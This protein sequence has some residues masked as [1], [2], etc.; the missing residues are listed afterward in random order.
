MKPE[1]KLKVFIDRYSDPYQ[2]KLSQ[3]LSFESLKT[4]AT[5]V[6]PGDPQYG[7]YEKRVSIRFCGLSGLSLLGGTE[8]PD[9][10][11]ATPVKRFLELLSNKSGII[12]KLNA[13]KIYV[14]IKLIFAYPYSDFMY[15]IVR[16]ENSQQDGFSTECILKG[17]KPK[18]NFQISKKL[19][20]ADL[21]KTNTYKHLC[22][23]LETLQEAVNSSRP[24]F[25]HENNP[26]RL[27]I[28][29]TPL[30]ILVC[31]L[32]IN[33]NIF[34]DPYIYA[35]NKKQSQNLSLLAPISYIKIPD[36]VDQIPFDELDESREG[37]IVKRYSSLISHFRFL[38]SHPLTMYSTDATRYDKGDNG[39]LAQIKEPGE[40]SYRSKA[41]RILT[42]SNTSAQYASDQWKQYCKDE[43][44]SYCSKFLDISSVK[45]ASEIKRQTPK[46]LQIFIVGAWDK[47]STDQ[48]GDWSV[49]MKSID[50]SIKQYFGKNNQKGLRLNPNI[51]DASDGMNIPEAVFKQLNA[52]QLGIVIQTA[53]LEEGKVKPNIFFEQGYLAGRLN[54]RHSRGEGLKKDLVFIFR[55][56]KSEEATDIRDI[57]F[58]AFDDVDHFKLQFFRFVKWLWDVTELNSIYAKEIIEEH[59]QIL[60]KD[61]DINDPKYARLY[62]MAHDFIDQI[63][64]WEEEHERRAV[65]LQAL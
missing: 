6:K 33:R 7:K 23:S 19:C 14:D 59:I 65:A 4:E 42:S 48:N 21:V 55:Q 60:E 3:L 16:A 15:D 44:L 12:D 10:E 37:I 49:Y 47:K 54:K 22:S 40:I 32:K 63:D 2:R 51:V 28:K 62:R 27:I 24:L 58:T 5:I 25:N 64:N 52:A 46:P 1:F 56:D 43:L 53:T 17:H 36:L 29:F 35:K 30:N 20:Y 57:A 31:L 38:W 39:T 8:H 61:H 13:E 9:G 50:G 11:R 34:M 45:E 41:R 18:T 26:N